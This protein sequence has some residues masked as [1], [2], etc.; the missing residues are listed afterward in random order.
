MSIFSTT[1][2]KPNT[3]HNIMS[4]VL[5]PKRWI[6]TTHICQMSITFLTVKFICFWK[7]SISNSEIKNTCTNVQA[8]CSTEIRP[9]WAQEQTRFYFLAKK[10]ATL[11][12]IQKKPLFLHL[13]GTVDIGPSSSTS[14]VQAQTLFTSL[15][16][17]STTNGK[18][19]QQ[20]TWK[21]A[22]ETRNQT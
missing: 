8:Y 2:L 17:K 1:K 18:E 12:A 20:L 5:W 7:T 22:G 3:L 15:C 6:Y 13:C 11:V 14:P 19:D 21:L 4:Y 9:A 10:S 16:A